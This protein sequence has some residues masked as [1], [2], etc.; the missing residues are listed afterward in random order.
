MHRRHGFTLV[1]LLVVIAIISVLAALLLPALEGAMQTA[2]RVECISILRRNYPALVAFAGDHDGWLPSTYKNSTA[3]VSS[4]DPQEKG[5]YLYAATE[6]RLVQSIQYDRGGATRRQPQGW[7]FLLAEGY[8]GSAHSFF[9]CPGRGVVTSPTHKFEIQGVYDYNWTGAGQT[10]DTLD[11]G[12]TR[13]PS[14]SY[15]HRFYGRFSTL[16]KGTQSKHGHWYTA[17]VYPEEV[18]LAFEIN[19]GYWHTWSPDIR[20]YH[21][22]SQNGH[23][24]GENVLYHDG[25]AETAPDPENYLETVRCPSSGEMTGSHIY[26]WLQSRLKWTEDWTYFRHCF[27]LR[28]NRNLLVNHGLP[29]WKRYPGESVFP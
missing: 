11:I 29:Y 13:I 26:S 22:A 9:F 3:T 10:D 28:D 14:I 8:I 6:N 17:D 18:P 7:G 2:R 25:H 5:P 27:N 19:G 21:G 15:W 12:A 16:Y 23:G 4:T 24:P 1:E 20:T